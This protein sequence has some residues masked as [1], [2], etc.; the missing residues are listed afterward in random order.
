MSGI[1]LVKEN[2]ENLDNYLGKRVK[3]GL[4]KSSTGKEMQSQMIK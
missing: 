2:M 3:R 1:H 4:F